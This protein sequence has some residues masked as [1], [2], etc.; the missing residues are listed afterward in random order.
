MIGHLNPL[1]SI[2]TLLVADGHD[3]VGHSASAHRGRFETAGIRFLPFPAVIDQDLGDL[4]LLYPELKPLAAGPEKLRFLFR[5]AFIGRLVAQ[6]ASLMSLLKQFP[7]DLIVSDN[8]FMGTLPLLLGPR[9]ERP[10]IAHCGVTP[11]FTSRDDGAPHGPGLPPATDHMT[12][13]GYKLARGVADTAFFRPVQQE[14]DQALATIGRGPLAMPMNDASVALPELFLQPTVPAFEYPRKSPPA[15]L[16]FVG[17]LPLPSIDLPLP[18]W[19]GDVTSASKV[20]LVT[21]GTL[22]NHDLGEVIAPTLAALQDRHDILVLATTGGRPLDAI[23]GPIPDNARLAKFLPYDWLMPKVDL[24]V[25]N[26]GY[27]TVNHALSH[28]VPLVVAGI[29]EDKAEVGARVTWSGVGI[30][31]KTETPTRAAL[32]N[33]INK[34]LRNDRF[35]TAALAMADRFSQADSER[36]VLRLLKA[37]VADHVAAGMAAW[38]TASACRR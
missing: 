32:R 25:T 24:I 12:I 1:V 38:S 14:I 16:H 35:R 18:D 37:A 20:V 2:G 22:A 33:A 17:T 11:L 5:H 31:L 30:G 27:G 21:Q 15:S 13:L 10:A 23:P 8:L 28:G 3:V 26:G 36:E 29:N 9:A 19:A 4:D 34:V 6:H 7:A